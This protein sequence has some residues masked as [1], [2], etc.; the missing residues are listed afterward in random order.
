[1]AQWGRCWP[2][3]LNSIPRILVVEDRT[4]LS[5]D[6]HIHT[7]THLHNPLCAHTDTHSHTHKTC[8]KFIHW[9]PSTDNVYVVLFPDIWLFKYVVEVVDWINSFIRLISIYCEHSHSLGTWHKSVSKAE[10]PPVLGSYI[11]IRRLKDNLSYIM[12][13][14]AFPQTMEGCSL[15]LMCLPLGVTGFIKSR[16]NIAGHW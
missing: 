15:S 7:V 6:L 8:S 11:C 2:P 16:A 13:Q 12:A 5:S 4:N 10:I 1:M 3:S 14:N 9:E